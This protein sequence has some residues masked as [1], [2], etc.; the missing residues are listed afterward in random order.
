MSAYP[1]PRPSEVRSGTRTPRKGVTREDSL[2]LERYKTDYQ[3]DTGYA[4]AYHDAVK[5][6]PALCGESAVMRDIIEYVNMLSYG[7]PWDKD[8]DRPTSTLPISTE[9]IAAHC[10]CKQREVQRQ[11]DEMEKRGM[12]SKKPVKLAGTVRYVISLRYE[13]WHKCDSYAVWKQK[14]QA[15]EAIDKGEGY[16]SAEDDPSGEKAVRLTKVPE[17]AEDE[18][19]TG[20]SREAVRVTKAPETVRPGCATRM[21]KIAVGVNAFKFQNRDSRFDLVHEVVI[22]SGC[23][24]VIA[25]SKNGETEAK[26][27]ERRTSDVIARHKSSGKPP[28]TSGKAPTTAPPPTSPPQNAAQVSEIFNPLLP[29][30]IDPTELRKACN[31]VGEMPM[32]YLEPFAIDRESRGGIAGPQLVCLIVK[33]ARENWEASGRPDVF[34]PKAIKPSKGRTGRDAQQAVEDLVRRKYERDGRIV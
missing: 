10:L 9:E 27:K 2:H 17:A 29:R 1:Q 12:L 8:E 21:K 3:A 30:L 19:P 33:D 15:V 18:T 13:H 7:R 4:P 32:S 23:L 20:I 31:E 22:Q 16:V 26:E 34:V 28:I 6:K 5:L 24:I 14:Y 25:G 11:L